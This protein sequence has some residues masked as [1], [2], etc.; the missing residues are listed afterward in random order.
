LTGAYDLQGVGYASL[1]LPYNRWLYR[2]R[3]R[4]FRA[5]VRPILPA[6][7]PGRVLDVGSGTGF[8]IEQWKSAG[9]KDITGSD[10]TET[11]VAR[12]REKY[13]GHRFSLLD[14]GGG[15]QRFEPRSFDYISAF[16]VF[17]HIVDGGRYVRAIDNVYALLK[18]GGWFI[19]SDN[20]LRDGRELIAQHQVSRSLDR[21]TAV[22]RE[23]GFAI[24]ARKPMF[25]LMN[26]P[27]DSKSPP[28]QRWWRILERLLRAHPGLGS[29]AGALL[30]PLE[31]LLVGLLHE[32]PSTEIMVCRK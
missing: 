20:F 17:F 12:L 11:A 3:R 21:T 2:V 15:E 5:T 19:W 8:Y 32:S 30:Y 26:A 22:L 23:A 28:L 10:L 31:L 29:P 4:V 13:P 7:F 25:W 6:G 16:D 24:V 27:I 1:G 14:I 18:P 9:L